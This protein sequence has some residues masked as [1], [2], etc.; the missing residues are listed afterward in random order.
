VLVYAVFHDLDSIPTVFHSVMAKSKSSSRWL[1]E[2]FSDQYVKQSQ[3]DGYRS[4]ASYKLLELNKKDRLFRSTLAKD[5]AF[6]CK[7]FHGEG[8]DDYLKACRA[9]FSSVAIRKPDASRSRSK[10]TYLV[11]KGYKG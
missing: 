6:A 1:Q 9:R 4:R 10:E 3:E 7:I 5:G 8:F 11:A 2:H